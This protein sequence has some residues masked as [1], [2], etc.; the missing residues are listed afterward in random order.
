MGCQAAGYPRCSYARHRSHS[1]RASRLHMTLRY[2]GVCLLY[3]ERGAPGPQPHCTW[4]DV[5][6]W[7]EEGQES[8]GRT[9]WVWDGE[10][11]PLRVIAGVGLLR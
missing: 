5:L 11:A 10:E 8:R 7:P 1:A 2:E 4:K 3:K 9:G 6:T